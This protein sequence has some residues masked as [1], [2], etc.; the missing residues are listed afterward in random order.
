MSTVKTTTHQNKN[1]Y[2]L[3]N[4]LLCHCNYFLATT[5]RTPLTGVG[6]IISIIRDEL[7]ISNVLAGF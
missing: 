7:N 6:P 4:G 3:N 2:K 1:K 5:L